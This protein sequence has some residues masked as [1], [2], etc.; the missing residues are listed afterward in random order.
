LN[1]RQLKGTPNKSLP[2]L[3]AAARL[4]T[5]H[6]T[7]CWYEPPACRAKRHSSASQIFTKCT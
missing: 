7:G 4:L 2:L 3:L 5:R 1:S 6:S